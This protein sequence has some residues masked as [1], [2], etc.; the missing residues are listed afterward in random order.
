MQVAHTEA[1]SYC[2]ASKLSQL[3]G[4]Q[5]LG[6]LNTGKSKTA[7]KGFPVVITSY[8]IVM[9]DLKFLQQFEWKYIIVDEGHRLKNWNCK[10]L[11]ELRTLHAGNKMIL[12]GKILTLTPRSA[13]AM[14]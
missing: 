12:S 7:K 9:A 6:L 3:S 5:K 8:E 11:R 2:T 4:P 1:D 10:L 14:L 13:T